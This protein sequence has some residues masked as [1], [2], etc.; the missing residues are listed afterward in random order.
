MIIEYGNI[1][2]AYDEADLF[3]FPGNG[4]VKRDNRLVMGAGM[5]KQVREQFRQFDIDLMLGSAIKNSAIR[6]GNFWVYGLLV[7]DNYPEAKLGIFQSKVDFRNKSSIE[8]I[9]YS[10]ERLEEFLYQHRGAQVHMAWPGVGYGGLDHY[11]VLPT[12]SVLPN[13]VHI[14]TRTHW[15][16]R[17]RFHVTDDAIADLEELFDGDPDNFYYS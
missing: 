2:S 11:D 14:W 15:S 12:L 5:A 8:M 13:S 9:R 7:S 17:S 1:W 16:K 6:K 4:V 3:L 10:T